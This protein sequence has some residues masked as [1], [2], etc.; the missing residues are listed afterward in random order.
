MKTGVVTA[1]GNVLLKHGTGRATGERAMYNV[2]T[3][4]AY[5]TGNVIVIRDDMKITCQ[6]L[7]NDGYGHMQAT[8]NVNATQTIKPDEKYPQGD[9]RTFKGEHVDYYPDDKKHI[10]IPTGG[11]LTSKVEGK[12]IANYMEGWIDDEY[13]FG[14]GDVHLVNP[15]KELEG[16]GDRV[17]YYARENG[18]A[19]LTG[20]AWV[21]QKNNTMRGN[22][23]TVYLADEQT[24]Q[25]ANNKKNVLPHETLDDTPFKN[26]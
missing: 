10:V 2:N 26:E 15:P 14:T 9:V 6:S 7:T 20:N 8:G 13:Y 12:F 11:I 25:S 24:P 3:Q 17:D 23:L 19:V 21:I 16:G 4:E 18:K 1:T 22:R 5:L